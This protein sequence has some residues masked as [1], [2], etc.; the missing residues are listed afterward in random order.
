MDIKDF[1]EE[2]TI[3]DEILGTP[4][5]EVEEAE[6]GRSEIGLN[7]EFLKAKTGDGS[8]ESYLDHPLN[9]TKSLGLAR[10]IRG[11]TGLL[12]AL[13]LAVIDIGLGLLEFLKE[14]KSV[15]GAVNG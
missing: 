12:G 7:L 1:D 6:S 8:I 13:D 10:I 14:K 5:M 4:V 11:L 15:G 3:E 2:N 9:F